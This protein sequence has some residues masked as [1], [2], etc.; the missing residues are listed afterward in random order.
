MASALLHLAKWL[1]FQ[2]AEPVRDPERPASI[3]FYG[4]S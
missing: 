3:T 1:A 2:F 4:G